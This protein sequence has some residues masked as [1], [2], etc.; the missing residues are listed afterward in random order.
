MKYLTCIFLLLPFLA[1]A[2]NGIKANAQSKFALVIHGGAGNLGKL[3]PE[4]EQAYRQSLKTALAVGYNVL[5]RGGTAVDAVEKVVTY[6]EDD[7]LFNAGKGAVFTAEGK[8]E[9]DAAIMDG[10]NLKAGAVA[11]VT[12]IK[13]PVQA[14]RAV[15]DRTE[16]VML[17]GKGA[18]AFAAAQGLGMVDPHYFFTQ[19]RWD[20]LQAAKAKD[21]L[22][23]DRKKK[24]QIKQPGNHDEKYGTVGAVALDIYGH[25]AAA[26]STGGMTNKKYGRVGDSPMIGAGTYANDS[27]CA[28]SC[29]GWGEYFIRLVM[30]KSVSDRMELKQMSLDD[31]AGE[32]INTRLPALGGDGGLIGV[33][34]HGNITM[35]FNTPSMLRGY[36]KSGGEP[37]VE[38]YR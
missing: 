15:M 31:A 6:L 3:S 34:R 17:V 27:T 26:T 12:I 13:N 38:I 37:W 29:T 16:H 30:A 14:A 23:Q 4:K 36:I 7:S 1:S 21:S 18:E 2:Q 19:Y 35:P 5:I 20:A 22:R 24:S 33:D 32:M 8:N 10:S 28:I 9:L 25:L 11:G